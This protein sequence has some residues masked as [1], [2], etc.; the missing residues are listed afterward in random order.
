MRARRWGVLVAVL[1]LLGLTGC[2][3]TPP[4]DEKISD[5]APIESA[6][7][8]S[9]ALVEV[10]AVYTFRRITLAS[11]FVDGK[12]DAIILYSLPA[13]YSEFSAEYKDE[14]HLAYPKDGALEL[15]NW[16]TGERKPL[17]PAAVEDYF[18]ARVQEIEANPRVRELFARTGADPYNAE[19][20]LMTGEIFRSGSNRVEYSFILKAVFR[21][22]LSN[23][24]PWQEYPEIAMAHQALHSSLLVGSLAGCAV[25]SGEMHGYTLGTWEPGT[26]PW[27]M[28]V[29]LQCPEGWKDASVQINPDG[30]FE[31]AAIQ[32]EY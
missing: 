12:V 2:P 26:G 31:K 16:I 28:T 6:I 7:L 8:H 9:P 21:Y 29:A 30:S 13:A 11:C 32:T 18:R 17:T 5:P 15:V 27:H 19:N 24:I 3:P 1:S 22:S 14:L 23:D 20:P 4:C 25:G 10:D